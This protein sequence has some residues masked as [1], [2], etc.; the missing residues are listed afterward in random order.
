MVL[1]QGL[2]SITVAAAGILMIMNGSLQEASPTLTSTEGSIPRWSVLSPFATPS[3]ETWFLTSQVSSRSRSVLLRQQI[4]DHLSSRA[5]HSTP[6]NRTF[7]LGTLD[8]RSLTSHGLAS[9]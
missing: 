9:I 2:P 8:V 4:S 5:W 6:F 7:A 1:S 3:L